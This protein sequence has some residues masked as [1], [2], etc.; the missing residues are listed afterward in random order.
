LYEPTKLKEYVVF[1]IQGTYS[2]LRFL[3]I[4]L[5]IQNLT[6]TKYDEWN[7]CRATPFVMTAGIGFRW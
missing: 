6:D 2:P 1:G 5:D 3:D 4:V 7:G